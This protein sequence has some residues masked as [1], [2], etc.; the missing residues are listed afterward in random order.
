MY[1][2]SQ[3]FKLENIKIIKQKFVTLINQL[4]APSS[5]NDKKEDE[6]HQLNERV[7]FLT[8]SLDSYEADELSQIQRPKRPRFEY[9]EEIIPLHDRLG[10]NE[11]GNMIILYDMIILSEDPDT[12]QAISNNLSRNYSFKNIVAVNKRTRNRTLQNCQGC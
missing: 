8:E 6:I 9:D 1:P 5:H 4:V 3:L 2:A 7:R 10:E 12:V 11:Q